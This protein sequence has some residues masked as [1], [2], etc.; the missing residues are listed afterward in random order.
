MILTNF[1]LYTPVD[2]YKL[3]LQTELSIEFLR[4]GEGVDWYDAVAMF[5]PDTIKLVFDWDTGVIRNVS[6]DASTLYPSGNASVAEIVDAGQDLSELFGKVFIPRTGKVVDRVFTDAELAEQATLKSAAL[7]REANALVT[8]LQFAKELD[9][10]T[11][12]ESVY[13]KE[14]QRYVVL[15]SRVAS[16]EGYP[17]QIEWPVLPTK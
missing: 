12:E 13:L 16:Q 11:E 8:P 14:L 10:I 3:R 9:M 7:Q 17:K 2:E 5:Q 1:K 15:L 4:S 6:K